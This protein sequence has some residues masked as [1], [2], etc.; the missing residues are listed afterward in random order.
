MLQHPTYYTINLFLQFFKNYYFVHNISNIITNYSDNFYFL[1][2]DSSHVALSIKDTF[3]LSDKY[4]LRTHTTSFQKTVFEK[5]RDEINSGVVLNALNYG[6]VFRKDDSS[7]HSY[8]FHQIDGVMCNYSDNI[9]EYLKLL[10]KAIRYVMDLNKNFNIRVRSSYFPFTDPSFEIDIVLDNE[11]IEI[12]GC[13]LVRQ[14]ILDKCSIHKKNIFAFGIGI[15]RI[16]SINFNI[17][18]IKKLRLS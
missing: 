9:N 13:G 15:E 17:Q 7:R 18:N 5:Y 10:V 4:I 3:I 14:S 8:F 11:F 1:E 12:L 16:A 6:V 2:C